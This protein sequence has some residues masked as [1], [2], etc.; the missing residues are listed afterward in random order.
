MRTFSRKNTVFLKAVNPTENTIEAE[1]AIDGD[2]VPSEATM[3]MVAPDD[4]N[5]RN[6]LG[7]PDNIKVVP[8]AA[9]VENKTVKFSM[10]A[11]SVGVVKVTQ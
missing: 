11:F 2:F 7:Q 9:I 3:Q 4:E 6:S 1:I 5:A 8:S 10:P